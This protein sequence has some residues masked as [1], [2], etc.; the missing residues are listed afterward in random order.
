MPRPVKDA[1][2]I[3]PAKKQTDIFQD[4]AKKLAAT[5][6]PFPSHANPIQSSPYAC[7]P[8]LVVVQSCYA[9]RA[10]GVLP[11]PSRDLLVPVFRSKPKRPSQRQG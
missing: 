7:C 5:V 3:D 1:A 4:S 11:I 8:L 2:G 6:P 10:V 9:Q